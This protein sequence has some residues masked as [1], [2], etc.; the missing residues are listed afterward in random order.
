MQYRPS[1]GEE[2]AS[3]WITDLWQWSKH[4]D[5]TS[6]LRVEFLKQLV[7]FVVL[8]QVLPYL[9]DNSCL[10]FVKLSVCYTFKQQGSA[11]SSYVSFS[12]PLNLE[13][14]DLK[15]IPGVVKLVEVQE[16]DVR[17]ITTQFWTACGEG[18]ACIRTH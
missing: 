9:Q 15:F 17:S 11:R 12:F 7:C 18:C 2:V 5:V 3:S 8:R 1:K 13:R 16:A 14:I 6:R 10:K 4:S